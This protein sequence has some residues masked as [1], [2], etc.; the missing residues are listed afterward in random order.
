MEYFLPGAMLMGYADAHRRYL[1]TLGK[2]YIPLVVMVIGT[3]L[4]Y[5]VS[6]YLVIDKKMGMKGTGI[7][8]V[9]LWASILVV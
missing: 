9:I 8:G 1:N 5:Y 3:V 2:S 6:R 7:A 4:H